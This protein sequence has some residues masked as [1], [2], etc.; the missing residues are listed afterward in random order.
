MDGGNVV[1]RRRWGW[2]WHARAA[3][4]SSDYSD[5]GAC[6]WTAAMVCLDDSGVVGGLAVVVACAGGRCLTVTAAAAS[7]ACGNGGKCAW[8]A[9]TV[10]CDGGGGGVHGRRVAALD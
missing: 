3:A 7:A 8:T 6:A 2:R 5:D 4:A 10:C 9:A 1:P